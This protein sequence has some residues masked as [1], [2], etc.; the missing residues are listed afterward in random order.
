MGPAN[1]RRPFP[2]I[3]LAWQPFSSADLPKLHSGFAHSRNAD[4]G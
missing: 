3:S 4:E 1:Q 2:S